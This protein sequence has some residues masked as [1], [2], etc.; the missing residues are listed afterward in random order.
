MKID[1]KRKLSSR[2]FW[3]LI[4]GF[5]SSLLIVFNI[6]EN[7]IAQIVAIISAFGTIAA[8]IFAEAGVDIASINYDKEKEKNKIDE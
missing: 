8:Y 4:A 1:W 5:I 2:K 3:A 6:S 7:E